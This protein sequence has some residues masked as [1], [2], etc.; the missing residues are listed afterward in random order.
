L[1]ARL[2]QKR[3]GFPNSFVVLLFLNEGKSGIFAGSDT[4]NVLKRSFKKIFY[5]EAVLFS[6]AE[7]FEKEGSHEVLQ[8]V[9]T[10]C[11]VEWVLNFGCLRL[12]SFKQ[13]HLSLFLGGGKSLP[14]FGPRI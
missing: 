13:K 4:T 7:S 11:F 10:A 8:Y 2:S 1:W 5:K 9:K 3:A 14:S 12:L 6:A